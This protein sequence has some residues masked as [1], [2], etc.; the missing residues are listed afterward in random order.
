[1][2]RAVHPLGK[3]GPSTT[4]TESVEPSRRGDSGRHRDNDRAR[5]G[6]PT[7][8]VGNP[9][10]AVLGG[11]APHVI[12]A[13]TPVGN[14]PGGDGHN[15]GTRSVE[16]DLR[17]ESLQGSGALVS[18]P[19]KGP[20]R[21]GKVALYGESTPPRG[22]LPIRAETSQELGRHRHAGE[23]KGG[24]VG[25]LVKEVT[26]GKDPGEDMEGFTGGSTEGPGNEAN[27]FIE[28]EL[29]LGAE[30][31]VFVGCGPKLAAIG[32]DGEAYGVEDEAPVGH[33]KTAVRIAQDLERLEGGTSAVAHDGDMWSPV[34]AEMKEEAQVTYDGFRRDPIVGVGS[35]VHE[36]QAIGGGVAANTRGTE[37]DEFRLGGFGREVVPE[38]PFVTDAV[39]LAEKGVHLRP[40]GGA[41]KDDAV[42]HVHAQGGLRG[43]AEA[44][45]EGGGVEGGQDR[46]KGGALGGADG[47]VAEGA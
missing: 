21:R 23:A 2:A 32:K 34:K 18:G 15:V 40:C 47:L 45:E 16:R 35:L 10:P 8:Q 25:Q 46:G 3:S 37:I 44:S 41:G 1:M 33:G 39:L 22:A 36:V 11:A 26:S 5:V 13:R 31:A 4:N 6:L 17:S 7:D 19:G 38:E 20:Q 24:G 12:Q 30:G 43:G 28:N 42:V 14:L 9:G 29:G 27:A